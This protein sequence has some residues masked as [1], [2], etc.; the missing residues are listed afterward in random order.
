M[1]VN[2]PHTIENSIGEKLVFKAV[3]QD[4]AGDK[5][6]VENFVV[7]GVGPIMHTHWLQDECLTVVKGTIGYQLKGQP[8]QFASAGET[9]HFA[10]GTPHR[11]WNAGNEVLHCEG[12]IQPAHSIV[13]FLSSVFAAQ[14]KSGQA[15]PELFDIAYLATRYRSEYDMADIPPFVK[16]I[17]LPL[18]VRIGHWMGK[19]PHFKGAPAAVSPSA[20]AAG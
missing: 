4:P 15:R 13:F 9:V 17:V 14:N 20:A 1:Q 19:Y 12:Y 2:Y 8:E 10:K 11:F 18:V 5:L 16:R 3:Q 6:L 7:P